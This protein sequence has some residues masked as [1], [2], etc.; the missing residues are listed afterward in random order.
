MSNTSAT[1]TE[2]DEGY[3][4]LERLIADRMASTP[5][6]WFTT[7]ATGLWEAYLDGI[8]AEQR[9]HYTCRCCRNFI[10]RYGGLAVIDDKGVHDPLVWTYDQVAKFPFFADSINSLGVVVKKAKVTGVFR[11]SEK[12]LGTPQTAVSLRTN[13][14]T[15]K[16]P[17]YAGHTWTHLHGL[18]PTPYQATAV[19]NAGQAMAEKVEDYG[20]LCRGLADYSVAELTQAVRVLEADAVSRPEKTLGIASWFLGLQKQIQ[21]LPGWRPHSIPRGTFNLIWRA[22]AT[23][24][25]GFCHVRNTV[26]ATL[27]DDVKAGLPFDTI[28]HKWQQKMH[29][30]QYQRPQAAPSGG[31]LD[32]AEALVKKLGLERSLLRRY[33]TLDDVLAKVW[34]PQ[35]LPQRRPEEGVFSRLRRDKTPQPVQLPEKVLTLEK[36]LKLLTDHQVTQPVLTMEVLMPTH[37]PYYGLVTATDPTAPP[38]IQWDGLTE[39][40]QEIIQPFWP[41][42]KS[43][44]GKIEELPIPRNPATWYFYHSGSYAASWG[45]VG[46]TWTKVNAVFQAPHQW[47][48]PD[49]F[50]HQ[51][52]NLFFA[53]EGAKDSRNDVG[54]G[55]FPEM[56]KTELREI[57]AVVE[58]HSKT[59]TLSS[60]EKGNANGIAV[61]KGLPCNLQVR[62]T[63]CEGPALYRIDRWE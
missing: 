12:M 57:R 32:A 11:S 10:E 63:T 52:Q 34:T 13:I 43:V 22:V 1:I 47:Q 41:G 17:K 38:I 27:L 42:Q 50:T 16:T 60:K 39:K 53:L 4:L 25:L 36:F 44:L 45:L 35:T 24:P 9:Q 46:N 56:L 6:P 30:L 54:L 61:Q 49:L 7:D 5:G 37:G 14:Y 8:P 23:A 58:A 59:S 3:D 51:P 55:L 40:A 21:S 48:R 26:L 2:A 29:P 19:K 33:A 28:S 15:G 31:Q 18:N 20:V 62:V